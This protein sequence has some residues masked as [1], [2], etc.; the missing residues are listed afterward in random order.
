MVHVPRTRRVEVAACVLARC[1][2]A[3]DMAA[4]TCVT[5]VV[6]DGTRPRVVQIRRAQVVR[7][8]RAGTPVLAAAVATGVTLTDVLVGPG[9]RELMARRRTAYVVPLVRP[10]MTTGL[11]VVAGEAAVH[12]PS[13]SEYS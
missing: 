1:C 12:A 3:V 7:P 2:A 11:T 4:P 13:L 8:A 5:R 9:P 10:L 6:P